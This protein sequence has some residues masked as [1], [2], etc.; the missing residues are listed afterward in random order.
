MSS[1]PLEN[2][3]GYKKPVGA[4]PYRVMLVDDSSVIRGLMS[5][6]LGAD[7][8]IEIV[9]SA[10]N[11][12]VALNTL[13]RAD[14]E[15]IVLDIEMPVMD[16]LTALPKLLSIK[17]DVQVVMSST[18]TVQ[19]AKVSLQAMSLGAADYVPKPT[20]NRDVIT[21]QSF[22]VEIIEK[23]KSLAEAKRKQLGLPLFKAERETL[24]TAEKKI[25]NP[26]I[27]KISKTVKSSSVKP[28]IIGVGS[29][30]GGPQALMEFVNGIKDKLTLPVV[31]TQHM[32][33]SFTKI[34][35]GHLARSTGLT[36][37]EAEDGMEL[38]GGRVYIAPG[39]YHLTVTE[40]A[41]KYYIKLNQDSPENFC[42]PA[43]DPMFRS[44][45]QVFGPAVLG[46]ILTGM[47]HD[48]LA[49][50]MKIVEGGGTI[51]AQD[52]AT[53]V[54]WGMPGAVSEAGLCN[55]VLPLRELAGKVN[56]LV[57]GGR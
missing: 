4:S 19:N 10:S 29:S 51:L 36:C 31:V 49:G 1:I 21:S 43:V 23:I 16:G 45:S 55:A 39:N 53:S 15:I 35:A 7:P 33:P 8:A 44:L 54:V 12:Q 13:E 27:V 3:R 28:K 24:L 41:G 20:T 2:N 32:P 5:R 47:G 38:V 57:M 30:T 11:G 40:K 56:N 17:P 34:L 6:W 37:E 42:R 22:Q 25:N 26:Q 46:V 50:S 14:P 48:G 18:L 9:A 52:E